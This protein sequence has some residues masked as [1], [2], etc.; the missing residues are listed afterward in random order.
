VQLSPARVIKKVGGACLAGQL[1]WMP[2]EQ[3]A[4][5]Y[6]NPAD[7]GKQQLLQATMV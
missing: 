3:L 4:A 2:D 5:G 1:P 7:Q 6:N